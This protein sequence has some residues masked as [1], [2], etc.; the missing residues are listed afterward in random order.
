AQ[1]TDAAAL[2]DLMKRRARRSLQFIWLE[3][4][5]LLAVYAIVAMPVANIWMQG[6]IR[7]YA[8]VFT[9]IATQAVIVICIAI[10]S[11]WYARRQRKIL[12]QVQTLLDQQ[13]NSH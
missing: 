1:G 2:L 9:L 10:W 11:I 13:H 12:R 7:A 8:E 6:T 4:I 3:W 5:G